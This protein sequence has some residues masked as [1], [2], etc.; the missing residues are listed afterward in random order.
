[1]QTIRESIRAE[2]PPRFAD[3]LWSEFVYR[4]LRGAPSGSKDDARWWV[5]EGAVDS[6]SVEF[7]R[8]GDRAVK[9]T[10]ALRYGAG[11]GAAGDD[12][13]T[14]VREHL[15]H[16]LESYRAF[17]VKRCEETGCQVAA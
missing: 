13:E 8:D 15:R 11:A 6:G 16:D 1:M 4:S 2:V 14:Q 9:V 3:R 7:A 12:E 5:D 10:V 17:L